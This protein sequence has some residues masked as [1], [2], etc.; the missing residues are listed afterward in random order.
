MGASAQRAD[1]VFVGTLVDTRSPALAVPGAASSE[2]PVARV[3][4]VREVRKGDTAAR[5]EVL[6]AASG[7]SCGLEVEQG[8]TYVVVAR[9]TPDGLTSGLCDGTRLLSAVAPTDLDAVGAATS[10]REGS[11]PA[12]LPALSPT[13][14]EVAGAPAVWGPGLAVV[15]G[16]VVLL[17]VLRRRRRAT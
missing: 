16:A 17:V 7:A 5:T 11:L 12:D 14:G 1:V 2:D 10:P 8:R 3:F 13:V 15:A 9:S 6:T 4:E